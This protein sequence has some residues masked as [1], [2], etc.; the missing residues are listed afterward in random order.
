MKSLWPGRPALPSMKLNNRCPV[1]LLAA[2]L[3]LTAAGGAG[4]TLVALDTTRLADRSRDYA[5]R[6]EA[7]RGQILHLD[8]VLT[9]SAKI[10][11][12]TGDPL[13]E[14]RYRSFEGPL[15]TAIKNAISLTA[16][17]E[18]SPA[19]ARTDAANIALV[20]LENEAFARVREGRRQEAEQLLAGAEYDRQKKQY[21]AGMAEMMAGL[22]RQLK[23]EREAARARTWFAIDAIVAGLLASA[24]MWGVVL[25]RVNAWRRVLAEKNLA[26]EQAAQQL[27]RRVAERTA[28]LAQANAALT[29]ENA[30]R[31][32]AEDSLREA[33]RRLQAEI[34]ANEV[35]AAVIRSAAEG[36]MVINSRLQ[37]ESV[38]PAFER[39]TGYGTGDVLGRT[40]KILYSGRHDDAF[41]AHLHDLVD[42]HG[43][44][45]GEIWN[46][47]RSGEVY[48]QLTSITALRDAQGRITHYATVFADNT[49]QRQLEATLREMSSVDGLTG[50]ANRRRFDEALAQEWARA[51]REGTPLSLLMADIDYFKAYNDH[52]GHLQGDHCLQAVAQAIEKTANRASDLA[53]RYGG[54][55]FAV[56]LPGADARVAATMGEKVRASVAALALP[57]E[58][59]SA[60]QH[61]SLSI[62]VAT[63]LPAQPARETGL[64]AAA[65][66]ALYQAKHAGRNR[67]V[68]A[69]QAKVV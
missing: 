28:Q 33:N 62:G 31:R 12:A 54:E 68:T 40:P 18:G 47:R 7:L 29:A 61:V 45:H 9:M 55:E 13:W 19:A 38:N 50:I 16:G 35:A 25:L 2:A 59:S 67:V 46:K 48:P 21:A 42:R 15:D 11:A 23:Q 27:E 57:H 20:A 36:V 3:A 8:E 10:A 17:Y 41:F 65:D 24:V 4:L 49:V 34:H 22:D 56:I 51:L 53:A 1:Y 30:E 64:I 63:A 58:T 69:A 44:W 26:L 14:K 32:R 43:V 52:Y 6:V 66:Q 60:A 39:I 5:L 37:I